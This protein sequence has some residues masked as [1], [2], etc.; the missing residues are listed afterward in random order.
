MLTVRHEFFANNLLACVIATEDT[1]P[2]G[3]NAT[4][5]LSCASCEYSSSASRWCMLLERALSNSAEN[6]KAKKRCVTAVVCCPLSTCLK[7]H[8]TVSSCR[9]DPKTIRCQSPHITPT[10]Q[11]AR[12]MIHTHSGCGTIIDRPLAALRCRPGAALALAC[13]EKG[14]TKPCVATASNKQPR[15]DLVTRATDIVSGSSL[16]R[17][18]RGSRVCGEKEARDQRDVVFLDASHRLHSTF[19]TLT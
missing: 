1:K 11:R 12:N 6:Q 19:G 14:A 9:T 3:L 13:K 7:A 10:Q 4:P 5:P 15:H 18:R 2:S 16:Y 17:E 8:Q